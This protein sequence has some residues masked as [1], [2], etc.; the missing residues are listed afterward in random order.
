MLAN[1]V[2]AM[3]MALVM[4]TS[5]F[6][7]NLRNEG[8]PSFLEDEDEDIVVAVV[9]VHRQGTSRLT[10]HVLRKQQTDRRPRGIFD[11]LDW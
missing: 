8:N 5:A 4:G 7:N 3:A 11:S 10:R 2:F 6:V 9:V 1:I